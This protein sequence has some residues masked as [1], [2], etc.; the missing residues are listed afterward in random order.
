[1][2]SVKIAN[3]EKYWH[4]AIFPAFN[5]QLKK[6]NEFFWKKRLLLGNSTVTE[7]HILG[8]I[9]TF[10]TVLGVL[11]L[12]YYFK[13]W[14]KCPSLRLNRI[15]LNKILFLRLVSNL[16]GNGITSEK[17]I[18]NLQFCNFI[19]VWNLWWPYLPSLWDN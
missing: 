7:L 2:N 5:T 13:T 6:V 8:F 9:A 15:S 19:F 14:S 16:L 11:D 12:Y 1:M 10:Q 3:T 17:N 18:E 4:L